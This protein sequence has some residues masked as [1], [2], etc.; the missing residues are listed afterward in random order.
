M[1]ADDTFGNLLIFDGVPQ[2]RYINKAVFIS[3]LQ[4]SKLWLKLTVVLGLNHF[5]INCLL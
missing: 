5:Q 4:Y 3:P 1:Q 2:C